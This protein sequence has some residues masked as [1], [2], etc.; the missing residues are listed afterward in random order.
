LP[1]DWELTAAGE[2]EAR[3][4]GYDPAEMAADFRAHYT[5]TGEI[6]ADWAAAFISWCRRQR[7]FDA[8]R[9]GGLPMAVGGNGAGVQGSADRPA[10]PAQQKALE[11]EVELA[12]GW[13]RHQPQL[14]EAWASVRARLQ[15]TVGQGEYGAWLA[16]MTLV[17]ADAD[18]GGVSIALPSR[19]VRDW[20]RAHYSELIGALWSA[21]DAA[22]TDVQFVIAAAARARAPPA[23]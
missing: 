16:R 15:S 5:A 8:R 9:Q 2:L 20:V 23:A 21:A 10:S 22:I 4:H 7:G 3:R 1:A 13:L 17:D 14:G 6:R 11:A 18:A 12:E 19:F